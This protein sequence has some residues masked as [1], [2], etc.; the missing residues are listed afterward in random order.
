MIQ[1]VLLCGIGNVLFQA[2][3]MLHAGRRLQVGVE[4]GYVDMKSPASRL[5]HRHGELY[6]KIFSQWGGHPPSR[7]QLGDFFHKLRF[8]N[9][10]YKVDLARKASASSAEVAT[11]ECFCVVNK[12]TYSFLEYENWKADFEINPV[13]DEQLT[14][15]WAHIDWSRPVVHIRAGSSGD[16]FGFRQSFDREVIKWAFDNGKP[17]VIT[18]NPAR[19]GDIVK[20]C[21]GSSLEYDILDGEDPL[22]DMWLMMQARTLALSRST[23]S[24]WAAYLGRASRVVISSGF[25]DDWHKPHA[26]WTV[27]SKDQIRRPISCTSPVLS[28]LCPTTPDRAKF[29]ARLTEILSKQENNKFE[30]I[31]YEDN[32]QA[33]IGKKR[34]RLLEEARGQWI[35]FID[36]DDEV[37]ADYISSIWPGLTSEYDT[38][39]LHLLYYRNGS[40][41]GNS[42][43]SIKY[44]KWSE[45]PAKKE[46]YR[47]PNHLNPVRREHAIATGFPD[48][49]NGEDHDYSLKIRPL[50]KREYDARKPLYKYLYRSSK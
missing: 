18:D 40:F 25:Q 10:P 3:N 11:K 34:N 5:P 30:F 26:V 12:W 17:Y 44:D 43:H 38:V 2:A 28:I 48:K 16:N 20:E 13:I 21:C 36:D 49:N 27:L 19:I 1:G 22:E 35:C 31:V 14:H 39:A 4:F 37:V 15:K 8:A 41:G 23:L 24:M 45:N 32:K 46:Y 7:W 33:S 50:L 6:S 29:L 9:Q 47:C 42:F